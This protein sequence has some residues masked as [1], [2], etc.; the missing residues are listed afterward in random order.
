MPR[1]HLPR[2][3]LTAALRLLRQML[4]AAAILALAPGLAAAAPAGSIV[5]L[6]GSCV[7]EHGGGRVAAAMGQAV[8]VG[9]T[10][11]VP[12]GGKLK[13]RMADGS[14]VSVAAGSRVTVAAYGVD[15]AGQRQNA[16]L[17]L[18]QGLVRAVV[19]PVA[20][21]AGFEVDTAVGTAA[22]RSTD[23]FVEATPSTMQVG[24]LT[25]SVQMT[26]RSTGRG[27]VIP[28]RWGARL[29]AGRDPVPPRVWS[30]AEFDS[31]IARTNVP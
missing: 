6:F 22:V 25:G 12:P 27:E 7:I 5:G 4:A 24:V 8:E 26:S 1:L 23:W 3:R 31:V 15:S 29:E 18:A 14:V 17:R 19:A 21:P 11:E 28:A 2:L 16:Q 13:L 20:R 10:V 30:Q 9:D